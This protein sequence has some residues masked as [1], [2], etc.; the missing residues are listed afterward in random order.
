MPDDKNLPNLPAARLDL[1]QRKSARA[2]DPF[3]SAPRFKRPASTR[4]RPFQVGFPS[5]STATSVRGKGC[6][7]GDGTITSTENSV[8]SR[9]R[10]PRN[11]GRLIGQKRPLKPKDV[12]TIR[13]R[14]Q[15]EGHKRDLAMFNLAID[16]KLRGRDLVGL[17][18]DEVLEGGRVRDRATVIQRK[19]GRPVQF[20]IREQTRR[21]IAEWLAS[22]GS[23]PPLCSCLRLT[24]SNRR[25]TDPS[26][27][28]FPSVG[29]GI[30]RHT[31]A[32]SR[33]DSGRSAP[34]ATIFRPIR[35]N[36]SG[37]RRVFVRLPRAATVG[38][39]LQQQPTEGTF[40]AAG[41]PRGKNET[42]GAA[43]LIGP[44][45]RANR[46]KEAAIGLGE[47]DGNDTDDTSR[48]RNN[49]R[50]FDSPY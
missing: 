21:A 19:T 18:V 37:F 39:P 4:L 23:R 30:L 50:S 34:L 44:C 45:Y 12:W 38:G 29:R 24:R 49:F 32:L 47:R 20:E 16:S 31:L 27:Y 22:R 5:R 2:T 35:E 7:V 11:R 13:V 10:D 15:L 8:S 46:H 25:G 48:S 40:P 43:G 17:R 3:G 26:P 28:L 14:L 36:F 9:Q 6:G 42:C 41:G 1:P 33:Y